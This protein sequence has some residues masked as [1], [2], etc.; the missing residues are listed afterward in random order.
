MNNPPTI[1]FEHLDHKHT[2]PF[3]YGDVGVWIL[4][5]GQVLYGG[6]RSDELQTIGTYLDVRGNPCRCEHCMLERQLLPQK[7][8]PLK[9][10]QSQQHVDR[11]P[12]FTHHD[13]RLCRC[14]GGEAAGDV[15]A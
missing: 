2:I 12:G 6:W 9:V 5:N 13:G 11:G 7:F 8:R 15:H 10:Q 1:T 3:K 4:A 14:Q